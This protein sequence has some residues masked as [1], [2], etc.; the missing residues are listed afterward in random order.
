MVK[1]NAI[2][3][4]VFNNKLHKNIGLIQDCA[5]YANNIEKLKHTVGQKKRDSSIF[6]KQ[7]QYLLPLNKI[8]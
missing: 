2:L 6:V 1:G 3:I 4:L 8:F 7:E 5:L